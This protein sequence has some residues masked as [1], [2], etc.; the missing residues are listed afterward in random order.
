MSWREGR[1]I[2]RAVAALTVVSATSV[3]AQAV[4]QSRPADVVP[5]IVVD[6]STTPMA[7]NAAGGDVIWVAVAR[8]MDFGLDR[9]TNKG[10]AGRSKTAMLA[11]IGRLVV[12]DVP[13]SQYLFAGVHEYGHKTR[14]NEA[15]VPARVVLGGTP[16]SLNAYTTLSLSGLATT[17]GMYSAGLEGTTSLARRI[18][19]RITTSGTASYTDLM[20]L[21]MTTTMN[22][23]Y[24]RHSLSVDRVAAGLIFRGPHYDDPD[25]YVVTLSNRQFGTPTLGDMQSMATDIRRGSWLNFLDYGMVTVGTGLFRDYLVR[26]ERTTP[27]RWL[28]VGKVSVIPGLRYELTPVGIEKQ[29]RSSVKVGRHVANVYGRWSV[30]VDAERLIGGGIDYSLSVMVGRVKPSFIV[31]LWKNPDGGAGTRIGFSAEWSRR[32]SDR[33]AVT[34]SAGAKSRGY[35]LGFPEKGGPYVGGGVALRF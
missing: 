10:F 15:G 23:G 17:P 3:A 20:A 32:P 1:N 6:Y 29:V 33:W 13:M 24:I 9:V 26:G 14:V 28:T 12:I 8:G 30:P 27:V 4:P 11:R 22:V 16:W 35:L 5:A 19:R 31:D 18:E 7:R 34:T 2:A 21:F 25:G